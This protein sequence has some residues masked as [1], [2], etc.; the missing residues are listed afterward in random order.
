M[1]ETKAQFGEKSM[2]QNTIEYVN[3][4]CHVV[5]QK[6]MQRSFAKVFPHVQPCVA[7]GGHNRRYN[8]PEGARATRTINHAKRDK[9]LGQ[10]SLIP[11]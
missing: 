4:T 5:G 2:G 1:S 7:E 10:K 9:S 6:R 8:F 3:A 11:N